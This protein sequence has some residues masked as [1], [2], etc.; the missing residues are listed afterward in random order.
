MVRF[1]GYAQG[2]GPGLR[3]HTSRGVGDGYGA[4]KAGTEGLR[5]RGT[6]RL[7]DRGTEG[8]RDRG[9]EGQRDRGTEGHTASVI[10]PK[11]LMSAVLPISTIFCSEISRPSGR[12]S[13]S[14]I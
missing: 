14:S 4:E 12:I 1:C 3:V 10:A 8:Q 7:R 11:A 13:S 2:M 6:K 9:T 5:D